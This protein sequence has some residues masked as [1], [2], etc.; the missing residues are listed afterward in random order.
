MGQRSA[1]EWT[2]AT[3]NPT[4]GCTKV[5]A[6]C[7]NC[8]AFALA[9]RRLS[10]TYRKQLPVFDTA[11]NRADPF[12]VRLWEKR[13]DEPA[14][15]S[16]PTVIFVNSMSDLFHV[17]IPEGYIRRVFEVMLR[18]DRHIYQVLTKRPARALRFLSRNADLFPG[19]IPQHIWMGTSVENQDAAYRV[20]HLRALRAAT[21]FLSCEPLL[22]P[23]Q[24][25]LSGIHWVIV[26][27]ESGNGY[28]K[29]NLD[30]ARGVRDQSIAAGVPFFFK[31]LGGHTSKAGGR[32]LDGRTWDEMPASRDPA[33]AA[34]SSTC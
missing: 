29:L 17:D 20:G 10:A 14:K 30:W 4:T 24:L 12:S 7:D 6:G 5:S 33:L 9:H 1:I 2:Q 22:G 27:G 34:L 15:W 19:E 32:L 8:Y 21:R 26:G 13:L 25:D 23:L 28:R 18:V 3:W 31:Q 11:E 16:Q